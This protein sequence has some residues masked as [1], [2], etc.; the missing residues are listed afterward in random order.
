LIG[1]FELVAAFFLD[2]AIGD[3]RWLPHPVRLIGR[4]IAFLENAIRSRIQ[5]DRER[6]A[7]VL[8]VVLIVLP[9]ALLAFLIREA[10]LLPGWGILAF[11]AA[12]IMVY[13]VATTIALREL[14]SSA[15]LVLSSVKQGD[16]VAARGNLS[17]IV[18]RDT[19]NL[20]ED[21]VRRAVI[22]T[23]SENLSDGVIAPLFYLAIGGL[24]L[25]IAYKAINTLDSMVGYKNEKYLSFGWAA[26]RLDDVANYVPARLTGMLIVLA[27][28]C[29]FLFRQ[30]GSALSLARDAFRVMR[31]DGRNHTSP[32]SGIPEAAM[33]GCLGV[34]LGGPSTYGGVLVQKPFIGDHRTNDY[35]LA[36]EQSIGI[37]LLASCIAVLAAVTS[38]WLRVQV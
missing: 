21:G 8:L 13:L 20:D 26:A 14:V 5:K 7:G 36:S 24:P 31:R 17:M 18:G 1:P 4:S 32:N 19:Q 29:Y 10:L 38:V 23:V 9:A 22:E 34:R 6:I 15:K 3:P 25:A 2:L 11:A 33:A 16:L 28:F 30:P 12:A 37:V 27:S 35:A